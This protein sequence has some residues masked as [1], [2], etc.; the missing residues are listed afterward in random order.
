[1]IT[2]PTAPGQ[3]FSACFLYVQTTKMELLTRFRDGTSVDEGSRKVCI[4]FRQERC[5]VKTVFAEK[6]R[7][8][9]QLISA[10]A[11]FNDDY[12]GNGLR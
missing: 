11:L 3:T 2:F 5:V 4:I 1:M 9:V 8:Q 7:L 6:S 10:I 12:L